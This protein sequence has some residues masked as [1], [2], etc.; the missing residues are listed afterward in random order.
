MR[1]S[2]FCCTM[3]VACCVF[4]GLH[5]PA[6]AEEEPDSHD[7]IAPLIQELFS[8]PQTHSRS[9]L[10]MNSV[11]GEILYEKNI[12]QKSSI[13]SITKLM[14]AMIVLDSG[15]SLDELITITTDDID[16]VKG[17]SSRLPIGASFS[18]R[19]LLLLMIMSSENRAA[20]A[21]ARA[22]PNG[23]SAGFFA[24][25]NKKARQIGMTQTHF[26]DSSGLRPDNRSTA[27]DLTH[28][29]RAAYRYPLIR[30]F[31]TQREHL[32]WVNEESTLTYMNT[33][34]LVREGNWGVQLSKT[35]F[36]NEAG[37]CLV[38]QVFIGS[39]PVFMV[40]L[41]A[42]TSAA[43]TEDARQLKAWLETQPQIW[44][45]S[46]QSEPVF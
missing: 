16:R 14:T 5:S 37:R 42:R 23:G 8:I 33:N 15:A 38:M 35:G 2:R 32:T 22:H 12:Y 4:F 7:L 46:L 36:I 20:S 24:A 6:F 43:R 18:R 45:P 25:M 34:I 10:V 11:S 40:F 44:L 17:T 9:V 29:I 1:F 30:E 13:A 3:I 21:L 19:E 31:S 39:T 41:G 28:L 26:A 27:M